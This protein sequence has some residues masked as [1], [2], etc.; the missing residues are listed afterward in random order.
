MSPTPGIILGLD[1]LDLLV[2][3][4]VRW[5]ILTSAT[6]AAF[7]RAEAHLV[8][9]TAVEA[10]HLIQQENIAAIR[11][12]TDRGRSRLAERLVPAPY[13]F[14]EVPR[15]VPVEVI[16]ACHAAELA[17]AASPG[18][19]A[20]AAKRLLTAIAA[21]AAYRLEGY[22]D[23]PWCWTR[24]ARRSGP[25]IAVGGSWRPPLPG[26][27]WVDLDV[28]AEHWEGA[29]LVIV[30][31]EVATTLPVLPPRAGV[32]LLADHDP[33]DEVWEAIIAMDDQAVVMFWPTCEPWLREQLRDPAP[34]FVEHRAAPS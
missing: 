20:S 33:A 25:P 26:V 8:V 5:K 16:K 2:S 22:A 18:W 27:T 29:S 13:S 28:V 23:A 34:E 21:A 15:L 19:S 10:G 4:A 9:A 30:T 3:A 12:L 6:A 11:W 1:H 32:F 24:P 7:S 31:T 17:C 14:T